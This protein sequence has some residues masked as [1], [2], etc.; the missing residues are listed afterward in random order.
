MKSFI[1]TPHKLFTLALVIGLVMPNKAQGNDQDNDQELSQEHRKPTTSSQQ[2]PN[3][4]AAVGSAV[5]A[6]PTHGF[7]LPVSVPNGGTGDA[8]LTAHGVLIGEGVSA[9]AVVAPFAIPGVPLVSTGATSDP[10]YGIAE[11]IGGGTGVPA[12][13]Q[14]AVLVG[15]SDAFGTNPI[16]SLAAV[17]GKPL[18]SGAVGVLPS[19]TTLGVAGGGTGVATFAALNSLII[20]G[21]GAATAVQQ[22]VGGINGLPLVSGGAG[23]AP[24]YAALGVSG[25]GTGAASL[26]QNAVL[27]GGTASSTDSIHTVASVEGKALVSGA[28]TVAPTFTELGVVGGGT[29]VA[30]FAALNSL[31]ISGTGAAT[32]VQQVV[33]GTNGLPLVSGGAGVAPTYAALGVVGG[34]TGVATLAA[35]RLLAGGTATDLPL[36]QVAAGTQNQVLMSN[37][38]VAL[39]TWSTGVLLGFTAA[40]TGTYT[41]LATD[42]VVRVDSTAAVEVI[43]PQTPLTGREITVKDS[44]GNATNFDITISTTGATTIDGAN[45]RVIDTNYG[46]VTVVFNGTEYNIVSVYPG[47]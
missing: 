12:F 39:P 3:A 42:Q 30:T 20:S 8:T 34:G 18:V 11:V 36:Q 26:A 6:H 45:T 4:D 2:G 44:T 25:G 14:N 27:I 19:F 16:Q 35:Y 17:T 46:A 32:A 13:T 24:T 29:G 10:E 43:L 28:A 21:S 22:V 38:G 7:T 15:G 40:V 33:G 31:I 23:V 9:I 5:G 37:T 1:L 47:V 41:V